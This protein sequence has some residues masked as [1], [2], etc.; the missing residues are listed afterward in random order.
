[1]SSAA[2][3]SVTFS[4][5]LCLEAYITLAVLLSNLELLTTP[6]LLGNPVQIL[7][8]SLFENWSKLTSLWPIWTLCPSSRASKFVG[9]EGIFN[10]NIEST[11]SVQRSPWAMSCAVLCV[12]RVKT[13]SWFVH[14]ETARDCSTYLTLW[15]NMCLYTVLWLIHWQQK[16]CNNPCFCSGK[17]YKENWAVVLMWM[18]SLALVVFIL[19]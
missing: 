1:M 11:K 17:M 2:A 15:L 4:L 14:D 10:L 5:G 6:S 19:Y 16:V 12:T 18:L 7:T 8:M 9:A 13:T 3:V